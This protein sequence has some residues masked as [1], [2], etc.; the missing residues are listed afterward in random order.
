MVNVVKKYIWAYIPVLIYFVVVVIL[1]FICFYILPKNTTLMAFLGFCFIYAYI[2]IGVHILGFLFGKTSVKRMPSVRVSACVV[3][4]VITFCL[5][6]LISSMK[7]VFWDCMYFNYQFHF[8]IFID[9]MIRSGSIYISF[10]S[11][12]SFSMGEIIQYLKHKHI[13]NE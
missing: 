5:M 3:Y 6:I 9:Q 7:Y 1:Y 8:S 11:L 2:Y 10:G 13:L 4:A 12:L